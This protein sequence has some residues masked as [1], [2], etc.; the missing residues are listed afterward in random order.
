MTLT[1]D[2]LKAIFPT[3]PRA[4]RDAYLPLLVSAMEEFAITTRR[5]ACAFLAQVGHESAD[6]KYF[7]EIA[8]GAAYEGRR[9]LGNTSRGDGRKYKGRSPIQITGKKNYL[10]AGNALGL[11]LLTRPHLLSIPEH[12]FRASAWWWKEH[13]LN[14]LADLLNLEAIAKDLAVFD[15]ITK[16]INGGYNGRV[17]RQRRYLDC[18]VALNE[19]DFETL[20]GPLPGQE[21]PSAGDT[22]NRRNNIPVAQ[23]SLSIENQKPAIE[24]NAAD[25]ETNSNLFDKLSASNQAK[26]AGSTA[27]KKIGIRLGR[28]LILLMTALEA[29]N[30]YAWLGLGIFVIGLA[31]LIYYERK[32]LAKAAAYIVAK[33]KARL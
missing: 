29:G 2:Q 18:I 26:V 10:A 1:A 17:D 9:D 31:V 3:L 23:N 14:E 20:P 15:R 21:E 6:L 25:S 24:T 4:K 16:I 33:V 12:G 5:R 32:E 11:D 8:S 13:E 22:V 28:P 7:E 19:E 27:A 30:F